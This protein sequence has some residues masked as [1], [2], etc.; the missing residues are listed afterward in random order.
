MLAS[1]GIG[2]LAPDPQPMSRVRHPYLQWLARA[3]YAARGLVFVILACF[4]VVAALDAHT[5]PVDGKEALRAVLAQPFG[6]ALLIGLIVGLLCF[7]L[8]RETQCILDM[9]R[10]GSDLNGMARRAV[11]GMAG[12]FYVA[13]AAVSLAMLIGVHTPTSE[14]AVRDWTEWLLD[15]P[16]GRL[17]VGAIGG[18]VVVA[19]VCIGVAGVRAEFRKRLALKEKPRRLVTALGIAGYLTRSVVICLVGL[20]LVFAALHENAHEATGLAGALMV[21]KSR[22]Y[23]RALLGVTAFGLLAFGFYGLAE[24]V[25]RRVDGR[26]LT[27]RLGRWRMV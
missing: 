12:V 2:T 14:R 24:A 26:S 22:P 6:S 10:L 21:I 20:F 15:Q 7:A 1:F 9:D 19:G 16:F 8:W 5:R 11:Y 4:T 18:A 27:A 3:G 17:T 25:F 13:F 23:G